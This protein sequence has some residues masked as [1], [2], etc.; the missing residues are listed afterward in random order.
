LL[1]LSAYWAAVVTGAVIIAAV[2]IGGFVKIDK[3]TNELQRSGVENLLA[4]PAGAG[5]HT[6]HWLRSKTLG[7]RSSDA[8]RKPGSGMC[9][10]ANDF[11]QII[12]QG[13]E[14][15]GPR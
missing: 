11:T 13:A 2:A 12:K 14:D 8:Q 9:C 5:P 10:T 1:E 4:G 7:W 6:D 15:N 3:G